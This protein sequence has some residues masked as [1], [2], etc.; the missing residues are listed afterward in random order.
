MTHL[1]GRGVHRTMGCGH[2]KK[3]SRTFA[4]LAESEAVGGEHL[5]KASEHYLVKRGKGWTPS[6][7]LPLG[8]L[9]LSGMGDGGIS[10][11]VTWGIDASS[12]PVL[13]APSLLS[14][15]HTCLKAGSTFLDIVVPSMRDGHR[16]IS[17][18]YKSVQEHRHMG[19]VGRMYQA[20][21]PT[22]RG[23]RTIRPRLCTIFDFAAP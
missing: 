18:L 12:I 22:S 15:C 10:T 9:W 19:G 8:I 4:F 13:P 23:P 16:K 2:S 5:K 3:I 11:Y 21:T 7:V 17:W 1:M 20:T 6:V 14:I